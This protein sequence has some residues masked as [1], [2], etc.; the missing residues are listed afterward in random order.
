MIR[1]ISYPE[2]TPP[3]RTGVY[4]LRTHLGAIHEITSIAHSDQVNKNQ[5]NEEYF[6][7]FAYPESTI[8]CN[9]AEFCFN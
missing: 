6:V 4:M 8:A 9:F 3:I 1:K 7:I 5:E 2:F